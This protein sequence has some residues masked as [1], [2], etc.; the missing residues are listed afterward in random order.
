MTGR[1]IRLRYKIGRDGIV[2][3][4]F[5]IKTGHI[6]FGSTVVSRR[7]PIGQALCHFFHLNYIV[8]FELE[9]KDAED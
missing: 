6:Q 3:N 5:G 1:L 2:R 9:G 8:Y 7:M 4:I